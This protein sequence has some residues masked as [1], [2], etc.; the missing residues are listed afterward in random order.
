VLFKER[1]K[2]VR[3]YGCTELS[4]A[5]LKKKHAGLLRRRW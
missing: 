5:L 2:K 1:E 4:A 3:Y